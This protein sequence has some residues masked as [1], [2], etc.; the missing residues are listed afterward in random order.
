MSKESNLI[1]NINYINKMKKYFLS[2]AVLAL[3]SCAGST[4]QGESADSTATTDSAVTTEVVAP[5]SLVGNWEGE[6]PAA[7]AAVSYKITLNLLEDGTFTAD[8]VPAEGESAGKSFPTKGTYTIADGI[9]TLATE[10]EEHPTRYSIQGEELEGIDMDG[11][12]APQYRL[13]RVI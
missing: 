4:K 2:L 10:G 3:A 5:V 8:A 13:K 11:N 1:N 6:H 9:L 12:P 7:D